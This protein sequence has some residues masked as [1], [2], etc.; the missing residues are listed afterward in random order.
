MKIRDLIANFRYL[1][2]SS[3]YARDDRIILFGSWFGCNF[4]DTSRCLYQYLSKNKEKY[5]L[6]HV[7]WVTRNT[8][9]YQELKLKGYEIYMIESPESFYYHKKAGIHIISNV[10]WSSDKFE[11]DIMGEYSYGAKKLNLWHG[12]CPVKKVG[13]SSN[14]IQRIIKSPY[15]RIRTIMEKNTICRKLTFG[16]GGWGDAYYLTTTPDGTNIMRDMFG[17]L[18]KKHCIETGNPRVCGYLEY[19][20]NEKK[21][22]EKIKKYDK[23]ILYLP[24]FREYNDYDFSHFSDIFCK[25]M[26]NSN[27]LLIQKLHKASMEKFMPCHAE[28]ITILEDS[29]DIT[30]IIPYVDLVVTDYSSVFADAIYYER[31][32]LFYIPDLQKYENGDNGL[33]D[34]FYTVSQGLTA[35]NDYEL[36]IMLKKQLSDDVY[37]PI[38]KYKEIKDKYWGKINNYDTVWQDICHAMKVAI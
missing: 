34:D 26:L 12:V 5:A 7:V 30:A 20:D 18:T 23:V 13:K 17:N 11:G 3:F 33:R 16:K 37:I 36:E 4:A 29:V 19:L 9:L 22:I 8:M 14:T 28:N 31:P 35:K 38:E 24:T 21:I 2:K 10:G 1:I 15:R 27:I 32:L 25:C 6:K